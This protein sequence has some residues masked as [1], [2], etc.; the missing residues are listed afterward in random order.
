MD[1]LLSEG[2]GKGRRKRR[3]G[4]LETMQANT[5]AVALVVIALDIHCVIVVSLFC[6]S[7]TFS[8]ISVRAFC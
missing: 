3:G 5:P 7:F 4:E 6:V 1:P 2:K 8:D